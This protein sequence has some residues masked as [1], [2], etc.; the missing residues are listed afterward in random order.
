MNALERGRWFSPLL[1]C[2]EC[3]LLQVQGR[4]GGPG[5]VSCRRCGALLRR[6]APGSVERAVHLNLAALVLFAVA[7]AHPFLAFAFEGRGQVV[8]LSSG[9]LRLWEEGMTVLALCVLAASLLFPL[10]K[11]LA[12]LWALGPL[13]LGVRLP[14]QRPALRLADRLRAWAMLD[15]FLLAV[16]VAWVK[17]AELATLEPGIGLWAF[18]GTLLLATAADA[19]LDHHDVWQR[20]GRQATLAELADLPPH[21]LASCHA[22]GQVAAL[23]DG[24]ARCP[25]CGAPLHARRPA[26]LA[27]CAAFLLAALAFY[28]PANLLPVMVVTSLG[29]SEPSTILGGVVL[30]VEHGMIPVAAVVFTASVLVPVFK[31][32]ALGVLLVSAERGSSWRRLERTRLYRIVELVGRWS[33]V[34]VFVVALLVALVDMGALARIEAGAGIV[35]FA[36]TVLLTMLA[37]ASFDTRSIWDP[38]PSGGA[39]R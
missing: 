33:M 27:R 29:R 14:G 34:D 3:G 20:F 32:L 17:M 4:L 7:N 6:H 21:R 5:L 1:M 36:A 31:F 2:R 9:V 12:T 28:V 30:L 15:V 35:A 26:A 10:A 22:C 38:R 37:S 24:L 25:R 18:L 11:M 13:L 39:G 23:R 16:I 8:V 19:T